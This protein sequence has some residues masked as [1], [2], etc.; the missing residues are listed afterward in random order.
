MAG[1]SAVADRV[2]TPKNHGPFREFVDKTGGSFCS[3]NNI[4]TLCVCRSKADE[5]LDVEALMKDP[6]LRG[7]ANP[8]GGL[9]ICKVDDNIVYLSIHHPEAAMILDPYYRK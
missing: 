2:A 5:H 7:P 8:D 6:K 4:H 9:D 1:K 3:Q